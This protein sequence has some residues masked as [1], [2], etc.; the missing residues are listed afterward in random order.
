MK[1]V[2]PEEMRDLDRQALSAFRISEEILMERA[3]MAV[4]RAVLDFLGKDPGKFYGKSIL[5]IAGAGHN[6]AD[7]LVALRDLVSRGFSGAAVLME[8]DPTRQSAAVIREVDRL[9]AMNVPV[10]SQEDKG[11][12]HRLTHA[13]IILDGLLGTGFKGPLSESHN[14]IIDEINRSGESGACIVSV[15]IPSGID[16]LTGTASPRAVKARMTVTFGSPKWGLLVD[17]GARHA[18]KIWV[19]F[20]GFPDHL[21]EG[22]RRSCLTPREAMD[23][24]PRR[25]PVIHKGLAGH[26]LIMGGSPGK[27]GAVMLSA[28][29]ALR[30]GSGLVTVLWDERFQGLA[31]GIPEVMGAFYSS[32]D[33]GSVRRSILSAIEGKDAVGCGPGLE[34]GEVSRKV[35]D[36]ILQEYS[37]PLVADAGVFSLFANAPEELARIRKGPLVLTPHPGE[38]ARF[39]GVRTESVLENPTRWAEEAASRTGGVV[40]LKGARTVV[41]DHS[42]PLYVNMTGTSLMAGAGMGDV[43]TGMIVS[44]LG[45][46]LAPFDAARLAAYFHG[47]AG[48]RL[49][50]GGPSRGLLSSELADGIP[51][52]LASWERDSFLSRLS[53][54]DPFYLWPTE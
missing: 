25:S 24:L 50:E 42:G 54:D 14:R 43:L 15:D 9:R 37:G 6:G 38:L 8:G 17:P 31:T 22:G 41:A 49:S 26:V 27:T 46:G 3:G 39:L 7:S 53:T 30:M 20:I 5:A 51:D 18:G 16:G 47:A 10:S 13:G 48:N 45:Q 29:G 4:S 21:R 1:V 11:T 28:R 12:R 19:S 2:T 23:L 35:L 40:L 32:S 33:P 44:L 34:T 36:I 52:L